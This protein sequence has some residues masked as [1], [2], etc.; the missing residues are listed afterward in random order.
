M[1]AVHG[2]VAADHGGDFCAAGHE[3]AFEPGDIF[4]SALGSGVAAVSDGVDH[5][6]IAAGGFGSIAKGG[7]VVLVAVHAA[8][9][10]EAEE[11]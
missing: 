6:V 3:V 8:I 11:V 10:D 1:V 9:G 5:E 4:G 2:V 7:E